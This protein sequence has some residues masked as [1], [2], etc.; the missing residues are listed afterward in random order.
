M[1]RGRFGGLLF[2]GSRRVQ[3]HKV[4]KQ[5]SIGGL[6]S[7]VAYPQTVAPVGGFAMPSGIYQITNQ[8]N[9]KRY[10]GSSVNIKRRWRDHLAHLRRNI[11][12]NPY[13]QR[14]FDKQGQDTFTFRILEDI[15]DPS[16]LI[17]REQY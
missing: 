5:P 16:Q 14:A 8:T 3:P 2:L 17:P 7:S 6:M 1:R 10:I 4:G 12:H 9:G 13:L 15:D 11:H